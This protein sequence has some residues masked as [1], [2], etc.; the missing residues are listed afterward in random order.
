MEW[1]EEW[2]GPSHLNLTK[3]IQAVNGVRSMTRFPS[4]D[5][6]VRCVV[7][8]APALLG[9]LAEQGDAGLATIIEDVT[10]TLQ[11]YMDDEGL[12]FPH[13]NHIIHARK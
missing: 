3:G 8:G 1:P 9:A 10:A 4:P 12:A 13:S 7:A 6:F 2:V 11:S 5:F